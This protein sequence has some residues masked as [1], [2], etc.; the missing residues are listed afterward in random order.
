VP[1]VAGAIVLLHLELRVRV[2]GLDLDVAARELWP[3]AAG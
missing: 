1:M 2:E 3:D